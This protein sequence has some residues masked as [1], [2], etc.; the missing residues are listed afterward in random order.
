MAKQDKD[1]EQKLH[2]EKVNRLKEFILHNY[3]PNGR[4]E[5][6]EY[7]TTAE[8]QYAFENILSLSPT[9]IAEAMSEA[10]FKI[11]YVGGQPFWVVYTYEFDLR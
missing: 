4:T 7:K 11:E 3:S 5:D 2:Q 10:G 8:L 9:I 1:L 6:K